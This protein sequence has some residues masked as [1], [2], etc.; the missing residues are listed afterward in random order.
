MNEIYWITRIGTLKGIF[1]IIF[2]ISL[3]AFGISLIGYFINKGNEISYKD[4]EYTKYKELF[5][6]VF[7]KSVIF[8]IFGILGVVFIPSTKE[9]LLIYGV[10][11]SIDY[12]K[13]NPTAKKLPDKCIVALDKWVDSLSKN[14]KEI[15]S[16]KEE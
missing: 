10:G 8:L 9:A 5:L 7:K 1:I 16:E 2:I 15:E 3:S 13:S 14:K 11:G 6:F 12:L 4:D